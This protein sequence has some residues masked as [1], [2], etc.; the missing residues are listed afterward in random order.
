MEYRLT[1]KNEIGRQVCGVQTVSCTFHDP[2]TPGLIC[3]FVPLYQSTG[4][5]PFTILSAPHYSSANCA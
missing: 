2:L 3:P 1:W 5:S 4:W